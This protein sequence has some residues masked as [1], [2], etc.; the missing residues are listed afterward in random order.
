MGIGWQYKRGAGSG[1]EGPQCGGWRVCRWRRSFCLAPRHS[2]AL[3]HSPAVLAS[4][5]RQQGA[6]LPTAL[7]TSTL[8]AQL[9]HNCPLPPLLA[10]PP[11]CLPQS[12]GE[13]HS[14]KERDFEREIALLRACRSPDI[15]QFQGVVLQPD[16]SAALVTEY[17]VGLYCRAVLQGYC[18]GTAARSLLFHEPGN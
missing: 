10:S 15:V 9:L 14:A 18:Q 4:R 6:C 11:A 17:M 12:A 8:S 5:L 16:G 2:S 13:L 7:S 1:G 3:A